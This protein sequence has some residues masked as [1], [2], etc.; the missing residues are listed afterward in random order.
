[1]T[2]IRVDDQDVLLVSPINPTTGQ[3]AGTAGGNPF[4]TGT[5]SSTAPFVVPLDGAP[6]PCVVTVSG[7]PGGARRIELSTDGGTDNG[8][9]MPQYDASTSTM[10]NVQIAANATHARLTG[11]ASDTWSIR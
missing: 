1:M 7:A 4:Q 11:A 2:S 6:L 3:H 5:V 8:W 9:F 10:V